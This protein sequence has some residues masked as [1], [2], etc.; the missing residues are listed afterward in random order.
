MVNDTHTRRRSKR[1]HSRYSTA[2]A[3]YRQT[4]SIAWPLCDSELLVSFILGLFCLGA[5]GITL[6]I[7]ATALSVHAFTRRPLRQQ[8]AQ[9]SPFARVL[10]NHLTQCEVNHPLYHAAHNVALSEANRYTMRQL[11]RPAA[12]PQYID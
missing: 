4:Q 2:E 8:Y 10:N 6:E 9:S 7:T 11:N 1:L 12:S 5:L 3:N